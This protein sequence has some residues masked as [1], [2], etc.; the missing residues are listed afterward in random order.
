MKYINSS[1]I[2]KKRDLEYL[3]N[4]VYKLQTRLVYGAMKLKTFSKCIK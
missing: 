2:K 1:A 3:W 4:N